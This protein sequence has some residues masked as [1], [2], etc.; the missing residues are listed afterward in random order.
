MKIL[1][2][3]KVAFIRKDQTAYNGAIASEIIRKGKS[4]TAVLKEVKGALSSAN[5]ARFT[6]RATELQ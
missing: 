3:F 4:Q 2:I 6:L 5:K 1:K